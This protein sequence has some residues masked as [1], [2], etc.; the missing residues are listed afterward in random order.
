MGSRRSTTA[1]FIAGIAVLIATMATLAGGAGSASSATAAPASHTVFSAGLTGAQEVPPSGSSAT[2]YATVALSNDHST[3]TVSGAFSNLQGNATGA[4]IHG[5]AP[6]GM[7]AGIIFPLSGFPAAP[8]GSIPEQSFPITPTQLAELQ[9]GNHYVNV[10]STVFPGGEIRGQLGP[11]TVF[12]ATLTGAAEVPPSG[13]SATG[14]AK[15]VLSNDQ[16]T[17]TVFGNF[18]NLQ[19]NA[20]GA[21]IHG[22]APPGM[23]AGIIFPL[24]GFPAA[25]SGSIPQQ[26]FPITPTQ[27]AQLQAGDHYVNVH[28]EVFPG[29]E[30]RGQL[31]LA[32]PTAVR[33]S[34]ATAVRTRHGVAVRWRTAQ[35]T[36]LLGFNVV[37]EQKGKLL[38]LN[39]TLIRS[40][41]GT[42]RSHAYTWLDR[43]APSGRVSYRLQAVGLNGT[44]SWVASAIARAS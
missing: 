1:F 16:S 2:G 11:A 42:A 39:R 27:L 10:H 20:T 9:A 23:N 3:I 14:S 5:P 19:G 24:T 34:S 17:I 31:G 33:V 25:P 4:H 18:S 28:S 35:E 30:I 32:P 43:R 26:S 22:P 15:V 12:S 7:N 38:K 6:P 29:G 41:G 13:S 21:H 37:R 44:R 8:S 40:V 36:K